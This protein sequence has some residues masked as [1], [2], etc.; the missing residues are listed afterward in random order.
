M[1]SYLANGMSMY[2]SM[3]VYSNFFSLRSEIYE[4]T[5]GSKKGGH[6]M[7]GI[8]YGV[9]GGK[10]Y[11]VLQNSWGVGSWGK[12]GYGR[13]LRGANLAGVETRSAVPFVWVSGGKEP[14]CK[15]VES[16][17]S[18]TGRKPYWPC[19]RSKRYCHWSVVKSGCPKT[20]GACKGFNG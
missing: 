9:D 18:S 17:I 20:C 14:A 13:I 8:A 12:Q 4:K 16:R 5:S 6:A 1:M 11:W 19:S 2:V 7:T 15:D 10:K 3:A